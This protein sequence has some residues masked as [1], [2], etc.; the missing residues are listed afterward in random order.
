MSGG[1]VVLGSG[2][3]ADRIMS[4]P[5]WPALAAMLDLTD[6]CE[7]AMRDIKKRSESIEEHENEHRKRQRT[8]SS[9]VERELRVN[10]ASFDSR[11]SPKMLL[12]MFALR[13]NIVPPA[14]ASPQDPATKLFKTTL[15]FRGCEYATVNGFISKKIAEQAAAIICLVEQGVAVEFREI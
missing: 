8:D 6:A 13:N 5:D 11:M 4:A 7:A 15:A 10:H 9:R 2:L 3:L 14:Y 12:H 1:A